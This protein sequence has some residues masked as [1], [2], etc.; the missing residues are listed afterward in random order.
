MP[1]YEFRCRRCQRDFEVVQRLA[2]RKE[3]QPTCSS[4]GSAD[5][6]EQRLSTFF[7]RTSRKT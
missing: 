2:E 6:V 1:V 4:C 7:P 3:A 5:Q